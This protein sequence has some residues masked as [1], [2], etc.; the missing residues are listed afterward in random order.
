MVEAETPGTD[1]AFSSWQAQVAAGST[2]L[3]HTP[4]EFSEVETELLH[5][6]RL[7]IVGNYGQWLAAEVIF[8]DFEYKGFVPAADVSTI[9]TRPTH[10]VTAPLAPVLAFPG[11]KAASIRCLRYGALVSVIDE[12]DHH[13]RVWPDGW[14]YKADLDHS[15]HAVNYVETIERL[16]DVPFL[17]GGRSPGGV[18][19]SGMIEVGLRAAGIP[20]ARRMVHLSKSLG[21]ALPTTAKPSR[22]DFLFYTGHCAMF[23]SGTEV[24]NSNGLVGRVQIES[25][26]SLHSRM[27]EVRKY[28][29]QSVRRL[30]ERFR[31]PIGH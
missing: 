31:V 10:K 6:E 11:L 9:L 20:C 2:M 23:V 16:I 14:M 4:T 28:Q 8:G 22:G 21:S 19:C 7:S 18:D 27:V 26:D 12:K 24:I 1:K 15:S 5:G 25:Y 3:R 29:F 13:V 17:W 30:D